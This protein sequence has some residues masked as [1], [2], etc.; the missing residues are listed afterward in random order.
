MLWKRYW[1]NYI[2]IMNSFIKWFKY[3]ERFIVFFGLSGPTIW[4]TLKDLLDH[5]LIFRNDIYFQIYL[6]VKI[7]SSFFHPI[8]SSTTLQDIILQDKNWDAWIHYFDATH[9]FPSLSYYSERITVDRTAGFCVTRNWRRSLNQRPLPPEP[10]WAMSKPSW[11]LSSW[12]SPQQSTL[13]V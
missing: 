11:S 12:T 8:L 5:G 6:Y 10:C 3:I 2:Q 1:F 9:V 7:F 4:T 13:E